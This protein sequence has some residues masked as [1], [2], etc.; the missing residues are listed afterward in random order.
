MTLSKYKATVSECRLW[1]LRLTEKGTLE[2]MVVFIW[3][4]EDLIQ[5]GTEEDLIQNG[6]AGILIPSQDFPVQG[7]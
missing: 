4:E 3:A 1:E 5:N 7:G 2:N 6:T